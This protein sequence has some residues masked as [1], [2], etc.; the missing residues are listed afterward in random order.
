MNYDSND[1]ADE[2]DNLKSFDHLDQYRNIDTVIE[3][4]CEIR[5][6]VLEEYLRESATDFWYLD[7]YLEAE[8]DEEEGDPERSYAFLDKV[9]KEIEKN[10]ELQKKLI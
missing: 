6:P 10:K 9:N 7:R 8:S 2:I 1:E 4:V 3:E 5:K